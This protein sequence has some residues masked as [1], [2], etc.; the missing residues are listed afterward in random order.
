MIWQVKDLELTRDI[1]T[2]F[3]QYLSSS[4]IANPGIDLT[5]TVLTSGF[6]PSTKTADL[7][8]PSEMVIIG[9]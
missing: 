5:V 3:E 7:N 6:W 1:K 9:T 8:L 4:K 2:E